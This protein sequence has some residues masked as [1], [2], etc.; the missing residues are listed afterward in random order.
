MASV[1][2]FC[3]SN[4][5]QINDTLTPHCPE[6]ASEPHSNHGE[7]RCAFYFK[8]TKGKYLVNNIEDDSRVLVIDF[9]FVGQKASCYLVCRTLG[10]CVCMGRGGHYFYKDHQIFCRKATKIPP[11]ISGEPK[12]G[13]SVG[14][15]QGQR[16]QDQWQRMGL[17]LKTKAYGRELAPG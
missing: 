11:S 1:Q 16:L 6:L 17:S 14:G 12:L 9:S 3:H 7:Q 13:E 4:R 10:V 5:N 8:P 15:G 2:E